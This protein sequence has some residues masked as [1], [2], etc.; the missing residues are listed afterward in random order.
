MSSGV[1]WI[2]NLGSGLDTVTGLGYCRDFV[3]DLGRFIF[4]LASVCAVLMLCLMFL[5]WPD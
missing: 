1:V 2:F 3:S 4:V 5:W